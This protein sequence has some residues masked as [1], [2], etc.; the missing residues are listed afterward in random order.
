MVNSVWGLKDEFKRI[1][2]VLESIYQ[3]EQVLGEEFHMRIKLNMAIVKIRLGTCFQ[4]V[5]R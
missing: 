2:R 1:E 5:P 4:S 3:Y